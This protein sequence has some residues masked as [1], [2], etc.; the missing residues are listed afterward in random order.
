MKHFKLFIYT[1]Y[2]LIK[3]DYLIKISIFK[4]LKLFSY[5]KS[6]Y[7]NLQSSIIIVQ[8]FKYNKENSKKKKNLIV[9]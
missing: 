3:F 8:F 7:L 5:L 1:L 9:F 6:K 4:F 2:F